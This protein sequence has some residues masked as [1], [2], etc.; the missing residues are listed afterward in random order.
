MDRVVA[1]RHF[2]LLVAEDVHAGAVERDVAM[3]EVVTEARVHRPQIV[4][5]FGKRGRGRVRAP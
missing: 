4:R 5:R 3:V 1:K 2:Q